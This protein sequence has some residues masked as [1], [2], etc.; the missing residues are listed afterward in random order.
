MRNQL[1]RRVFHDTFWVARNEEGTDSLVGPYGTRAWAVADAQ[2]SLS[3][4]P[5]A[6]FW[7]FKADASG[8]ETVLEL[9]GA[10]DLLLE[11][12]KEAMLQLEDSPAIQKWLTEVTPEQKVALEDEL[13]RLFTRWL[14]DTTNYPQFFQ[15]VEVQIHH[16]NLKCREGADHA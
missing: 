11:L 3:L 12:V 5:G 9:T 13:S 10:S 6:P 8:V 16:V 4:E 15:P 7:T 1:S 14:H 2:K